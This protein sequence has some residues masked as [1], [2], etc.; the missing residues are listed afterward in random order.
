VQ[1]VL[2][3]N[4]AAL[5]WVQIDPVT[6]ALL[7]EGRIAKTGFDYY[8][9]SI[10]VNSLGTVVIGFSGSSGTT[11]ASAYAVEGTTTGIT[12]IF[13]DP[14]LLKAGLSSY[15]IEFNSGGNRWGD[16]SATWVDPTNDNIFWTFQEWA[17]AYYDFNIDSG[18][19]STQITELEVVPLPSGMLL[20][21]SGLLGLAGW[22][23]FRKD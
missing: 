23:R 9:G 12:T 8:Y 18:T 5:R 10:A 20:L 16:Y 15:D 19:W 7:Q 13:G 2:V 17:D 3:N 4:H 14:I 11:F 22:R 21:G 1:S 6:N